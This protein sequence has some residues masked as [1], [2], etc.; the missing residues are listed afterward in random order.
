[1][2]MRSN[3]NTLQ[4]HISALCML[5]AL[6]FVPSTLSANSDSCQAKESMGGGAARRDSNQK[7]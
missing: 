1:M 6:M 7:Q 2:Y 4:Q 5:L 3:L